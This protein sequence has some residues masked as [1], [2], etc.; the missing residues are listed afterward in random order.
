MAMDKIDYSVANLGSK[1]TQSA[2]ARPRV[3][4]LSDIRLL[5]EGI[6]SALSLQSS[7]QVIGASDLSEPPGRIANLRPDAL[8]V[9][10]TAP[11]S[12]DAWHSI[13][14]SMPATKVIALGVA[15]VEQDVIACASAGVSGFVT[16]GGSI[17]DVVAAVHAAV[18]GELVCSPRMAAMLLHRV[19]LQHSRLPADTDKSSLTQREQDIVLLLNDGLSNKQIARSLNIRNATVK[20][21]VH[22]ILSKLRISRRG[23][24]AA[25]LRRGCVS[26]MENLVPSKLPEV[27][28][29]A[30]A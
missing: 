16:A 7:V 26:G 10:I 30:S 11:G 25:Q 6:V 29:A 12:L 13:R 4:V 15:E 14:E 2:P 9:D 19:G 27:R 8:L 1:A 23:E 17:N 20:N 3:F 24:V 18:R 28:R 5:R 21:H 22:S